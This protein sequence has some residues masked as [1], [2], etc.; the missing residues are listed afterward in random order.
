[1]CQGG[2]V[3]GQTYFVGLFH[4]QSFTIL[5]SQVPCTSPS[6]PYLP[7]HFC[8]CCFCWLPICPMGPAPPW[9]SFPVLHPPS[10]PLPSIVALALCEL[11]VCTCERVTQSIWLLQPWTLVIVTF[12]WGRRELI[13]LRVPCSVYSV[14][15]SHCLRRVFVFFFF[16][17]CVKSY[18]S[19]N[20]NSPLLQT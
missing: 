16:F 4:C 5:S 8:L 9:P 18:K 14:A 12:S 20:I 11:C 10:L 13:G 15:T 17:R 3:S 2:Q 6:G 1:M 19:I 7:S